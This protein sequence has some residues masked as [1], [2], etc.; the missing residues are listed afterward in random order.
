MAD[1]NG[2]R[3]TVEGVSDDQRRAGAVSGAVMFFCAGA[4]CGMVALAL[5]IDAHP[6]AA[7]TPLSASTGFMAGIVAAGVFVCGVLF[8]REASAPSNV[9]RA[10]QD[11]ADGSP[12]GDSGP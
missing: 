3:P 2:E 1:E 4:L 5:L 11:A 8:L 6:V 9:G 10:R 7:S 12:H